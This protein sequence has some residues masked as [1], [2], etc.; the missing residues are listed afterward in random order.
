[1]V[2]AIYP[3][4]DRTVGLA[5]LGAVER[6][7]RRTGADAVLATA[8]AAA[9]LRLLRRQCYLPIGGNVHLLLRDVTGEQANFGPTLADWWLTRGDGHADEVF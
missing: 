8:S 7:A 6:E 3:P 4:G 1:L 5:L 2:D 9:L